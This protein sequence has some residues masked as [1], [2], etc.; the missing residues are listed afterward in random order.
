MFVQFA[1][2]GWIFIHLFVI[3][4]WFS[5]RINDRFTQFTWFIVK[6]DLLCSIWFVRFA[7]R[8]FL[9]RTCLWGFPT[10][11]RKLYFVFIGV[12]FDPV[13][14]RQQFFCFNQLTRAL[15]FIFPH[16]ITCYLYFFTSNHQTFEAYSISDMSWMN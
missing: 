14:F 16:L 12:R 11:Y 6:V 4:V 5:L 13:T 3:F 10:F 7:V 2:M 1:W 15:P 8:I 9:I